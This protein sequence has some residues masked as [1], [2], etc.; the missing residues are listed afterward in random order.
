[1]DMGVADH[2]VI[3]FQTEEIAEIL[4][5]QC[6]QLKKEL[7]QFLNALSADDAT[8]DGIKSK[9]QTSFRAGGL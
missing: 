7:E 4:P 9:L 1:M 8:D 3:S 2:R 6:C 5:W